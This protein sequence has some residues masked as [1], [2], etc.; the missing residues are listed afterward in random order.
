MEPGNQSNA[1]AVYNL[2]LRIVFVTQSDAI[3]GMP[4]QRAYLEMAYA[5]ILTA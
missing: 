5:Q 3:R 1:H 4:E 2:K